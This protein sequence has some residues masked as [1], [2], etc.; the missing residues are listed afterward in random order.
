MNK[1]IRRYDDFKINELTE[2]NLQRLNPDNFSLGQPNVTDNSLSINAFDKHQDAIRA[3]TSKINGLLHSLS[4][5]PQFNVL[6]SRLSLEKQ[7]ITSM[8][9]L[10]ISKSN[11]VNYDIYISFIIDEI[12][13]FGLIEDILTEDPI[14]KSEVFKNS[15]LVQTKE[16]VIK[17]KGLVVKIIRK[18]LTPDNGKYK[19]INSEA[20]CFNV[21]NGKLL[22]I[23]KDA[24][25]EVIR[26][27]DNKIVMKH[28]NEYYNLIGD[29]YIYFNYWF[30]KVV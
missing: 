15:D 8:K 19:L 27:Y 21:D 6:K 3:A 17:I 26:S 29:S 24:E 28:E 14:F 2:F 18:W 22:R 5:T 10:R 7:N 30:T 16:W 20:Y 11:D 25:I 12:E 23:N 9:V 13:Y 4:N 1:Y